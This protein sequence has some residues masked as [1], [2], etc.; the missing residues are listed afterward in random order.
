MKEIAVLFSG[1]IDSTYISANFAKEYDIIHL[2]TY[3]SPHHVFKWKCLINLKKLKKRYGERKFRHEIID[4]GSTFKVLSGGYRK[5][6]K[7][8]IKTGYSHIGCISCRIAACI[9]VIK[10]CRKYNILQVAD[11]YNPAQFFDVVEKRFQ[12]DLIPL[13]YER[14]GIKRSAPLQ[15]YYKV[16]RK[17][18]QNEKY[19][20]KIKNIFYPKVSRDPQISEFERLGFYKGVKIKDLDLL[21]QQSCL[22]AIVSHVMGPA[23][24]IKYRDVFEYIGKKMKL[25][26][27]LLTEKSTA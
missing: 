10:Y 20:N 12:A 8:C 6:I 13:F 26:D 11:G 9:E 15:D 19:S 23:M 18:P 27:R 14:H 4:V 17:L 2:L 22:L 24:K 3:T 21:N 16:T 7:D 25:G 5:I 1:G